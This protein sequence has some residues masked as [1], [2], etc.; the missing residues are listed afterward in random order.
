MVR[1]VYELYVA[2]FRD[3]ERVKNEILANIFLGSTRFRDMHEIT[4]VIGKA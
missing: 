1:E 4:R 2:L 3:V